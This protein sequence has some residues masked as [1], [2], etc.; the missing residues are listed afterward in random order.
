MRPKLKVN[1]TIILVLAAVIS[2]A[3]ELKSRDEYMRSLP[4]YRRYKCLI[5]HKSAAPVSADLNSFGSDFRKNGYS[6]NIAL[7]LKDSDGDGY[8]NGDE[9]GD[10]NGDGVPDV[11]LEY[12]NP[13]DPMNVPNSIDRG[14]WG[15]LKSLFEE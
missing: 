5:C 1:V 15:I 8:P 6:W 10:G 4:V 11:G 3:G 13:G 2:I 14:T 7:A 12:S 9:I